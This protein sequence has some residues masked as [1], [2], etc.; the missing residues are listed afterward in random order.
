MSILQTHNLTKVYNKTLKAVD[1]LNLTIEKGNIYGIL[2]PNGSGK[3]TTL[4]MVLGIIHP[5]NGHYTWFDQAPSAKARQRIGAILE[6]PNFYPYMNAQ[7]NLEIVAHIKKT[8]AKQ[9]PELIDLVGLTGRVDSPFRAYSLGMKQRL[10]IAGALIGDPE[11]LIFDEPTNGLDPQGIVEVR[12]LL[13]EI[14]ARG[15]TILLASHIIDE[16]EKV[17]NHVAILKYGDLIAAGSVADI[18]SNEPI[19]EV[20]AEDLETLKR[21]LSDINFVTDLRVDGSIL[22]LKMAAENSPTDLN[23]ILFQKG[24]VLNHLKV[25]QKSLEAEFLERTS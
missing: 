16:V 4:G 9:I 22:E 21:A 8:D 12:N 3:T 17:C 7:K 15:K 6:T 5:T 24:V 20:G 19:I 14:G 13:I 11:V 25:R 18:L 1:N 23:K 10:A 2:G